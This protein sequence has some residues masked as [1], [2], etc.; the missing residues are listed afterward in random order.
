MSIF[1]LFPPVV[2]C[3]V[4]VCLSKLSSLWNDLSPVSAVS[5]TRLPP[6]NAHPVTSPPLSLQP[7]SP[8]LQ[9]H[10]FV[11]SSPRHIE[12]TWVL[13]QSII[14]PTHI[15]RARS[16]HGIS[17]IRRSTPQRR[18]SIHP[19]H[20]HTNNN[21]TLGTSIDLCTFADVIYSLS[22]CVALPLCD[23]R[24]VLDWLA[25]RSCISSTCRSTCRPHPH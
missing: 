24:C 9:G 23:S 3:L 4:G 14:I 16:L 13:G 17:F 19:P 22:F 7:P 12:T 15:Y 1:I 5:Q 8:P 21:P 10:L 11:Y 2:P 6:P 20:Q 25:P 18:N